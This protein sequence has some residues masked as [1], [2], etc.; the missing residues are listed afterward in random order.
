M[1]KKI[2]EIMRGIMLD[3]HALDRSKSR[4]SFPEAEDL[5]NYFEFQALRAPSVVKLLTAFRNSCFP[6]FWPH[7][8]FGCAVFSFC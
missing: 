6:D 1:E 8:R 7:V 2:H 5:A 3:E 4:G